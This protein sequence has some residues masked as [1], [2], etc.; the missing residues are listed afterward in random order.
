MGVEP[1]NEARGNFSL[2]PRLSCMGVE[3]GNEARESFS[4]APRLL[5]I[6]VEPRNEARGS[7]SL[8][9]RPCSFFSFSLCCFFCISM[10][11][12]QREKMRR[13]CTRVGKL[14]MAGCQLIESIRS[15]R[16]HMGGCGKVGE[17]LH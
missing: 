2:A 7:F 10:N 5:H 15:P 6:G 4:L 11:T 3:P 12:D 1:G 17:G 9:P 14:T 16:L 13:L 8:A